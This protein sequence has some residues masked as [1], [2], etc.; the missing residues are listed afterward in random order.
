[1]EKEEFPPDAETQAEGSRSPRPCLGPSG[2]SEG[3]SF[4][5]G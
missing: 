3:F 4:G 1:M 2:V 5:C